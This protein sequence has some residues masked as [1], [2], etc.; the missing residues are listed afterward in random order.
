M[1]S[2]TTKITSFPKELFETWLT[3]CSSCRPPIFALH[4]LSLQVAQ[5]PTELSIHFPMDFSP[6]RIW[7]VQ[8]DCF[9]RI[10]KQMDAHAPLG[11]EGGSGTSTRP[12]QTLM[13]AFS[14]H[15]RI[16]LPFLMKG[17]RC[18]FVQNSQREGCSWRTIKQGAG[19]AAPRLRVMG[20]PGHQH[21]SKFSLSLMQGCKYKFLD[22]LFL[23]LP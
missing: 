3:F 4:L 23:E 2:E 9:S 18:C 14:V 11:P 10:W 16:W 22:A 6:G 13:D 7:Q 1:L 20:S 17:P 15:P 8:F 5:I 12:P 21:S 19:P